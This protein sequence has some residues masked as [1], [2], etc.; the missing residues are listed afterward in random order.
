MDYLKELSTQL[1]GKI[2]SQYFQDTNFKEISS[3]KLIIS[4]I[5]GYKVTINEF[6]ELFS[7]DIKVESELA[8]AINRPNR[9]FRITK[10]VSFANLPYPVYVRDDSHDLISNKIKTPFWT[11]FFELLKGI[12]LSKNEGVFIYRNG[13]S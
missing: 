9:M 2:R 8:L 13:I 12:Q 7:I 5:E 6:G 1:N 3:R 4:D 11:S 10:E